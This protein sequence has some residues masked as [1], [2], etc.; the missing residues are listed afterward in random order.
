MLINHQ[1]DHCRLKIGKNH[2]VHRIC[3]D[4][5]GHVKKLVQGFPNNAPVWLP[6]LQLPKPLKN[7]VPYEHISHVPLCFI[8]SQPLVQAHLLFLS[9]FALPINS[10]STHHGDG[11]RTSDQL[12][13]VRL[14][15]KRK[16]TKERSASFFWQQRTIVSYICIC[17]Y[18]YIYIYTHT[19]TYYMY[20]IVCPKKRDNTVT[21]HHVQ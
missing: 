16:A 17:I 7:H 1:H 10:S 13:S 2:N 20:I 8:V 4:G 12:C 15:I 5:C 19:Y 21:Y 3:N 11:K 6:S 9:T 14:G 18:I